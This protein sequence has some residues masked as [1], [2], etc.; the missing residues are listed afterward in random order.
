MF[1]EIIYLSLI[2]F[3]LVLVAGFVLGS[4]RVPFVQPTLGVRYAEL[5]EIPIMIVVIWHSAQLVTWQMEEEPKG[6]AAFMTPIL[7]GVLAFLWLVVVEITATAI[8]KGGWW[9]GVHVYIASRDPV[10]GPVYGM[11]LLAF[12]LTPWYIWYRQAHDQEMWEISVDNDVGK[13]EEYCNT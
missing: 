8:L 4:I 2:Y 3:S 9:N 12:A 10:A 6:R 13:Q 11:T 1:K 7:I 5:L